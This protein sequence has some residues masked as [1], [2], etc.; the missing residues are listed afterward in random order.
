MREVLNKALNIY[1]YNLQM[2]SLIIY[3]RPLIF[4]NNVFQFSV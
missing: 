2:C 4:P 3:I 1:S